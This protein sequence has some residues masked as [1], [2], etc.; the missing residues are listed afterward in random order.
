M[1]LSREQPESHL[2][3]MTCVSYVTSLP[4]A[5]VSRAFLIKRKVEAKLNMEGF[6]SNVGDYEVYRHLGYVR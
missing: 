6:G 3:Q 2:P 1:G 4:K 5:D